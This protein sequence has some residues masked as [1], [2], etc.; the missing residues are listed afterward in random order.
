MKT[1]S[2]IDASIKERKAKV[3]TASEIKEMVRRG[4]IP[5]VDDVDVVTCGT[6]GIM[7]GTM[8]VFSIP[9]T[10]P[11]TFAKADTI[12]LNGVPGYPGPCPNENLGIVDCVVYGTSKRDKYYG[13]GH[14]FKDIV[15]GKTISVSVSSNGKK[16]SNELTIKDIPLARMIV[17]RGAFRNYTA[18]LNP[19]DGNFETIFSVTGIEGPLKEVSISGCGEINPLQN[20]PSRSYLKEGTSVIVNGADGVII[21]EGTRSTPA[22]PNLSASADMKNMDARMMGGFITS[23][24]PECMTSFAAAIP[25]TDADS[26]NNVLVL[27]KDIALP[28]ADI[29]TR[30]PKTSDNYGA[31][32]TGTD[33]KITV[34]AAKC[35]HCDYCQAQ[36]RCPVEALEP[37]TIDVSKCVVCGACLKT[38]IGEIFSADLGKLTFNDSTV[39]ITLRQSDR[40]RAEELTVKLKERISKGEWRMRCV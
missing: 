4:D 24:G 17:T 32:W 7:S 40:N 19:E 28:I 27:D 14:L 21:G 31:V 30:T 33:R 36:D 3:F 38:C 12:S 16:F 2:S 35:I 22:R 13:G 1:I 9:V 29:Q 20:D 37:A 39:P 26:L 18:F 23:A 25:I 6:F 8:A 10:A 34:D 5:S 15:S 11:G